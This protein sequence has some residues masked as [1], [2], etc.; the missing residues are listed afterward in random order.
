MAS[1]RKPRPRILASTAPR[2]A[3]GVTAAAIASVT[4]LS[5][6]ANAAPAKPSISEVKAQIDTLNQQA[7]VATENY[8]QAKERVDTQRAKTNQLLTQVAQKTQQLNESRRVLGQFASEQYRDGGVDQT[9]QLLLAPDPQQF[10][11]QTHMVNQLSATQ[12]EALKN[13]QVQQEQASIQ[14]S[15]A[16][17]SL[18]QLTSAQ[19][20]LA[21]Q[22]KTVQTKLAAAQKLL[23]SLNAEQRAKIAKMDKGSSSSAS[24]TYSG[25]ATG[26]AAAAINFALAQRGK[27]YVW[28]A[29]GPGSYDCSGLT[30][31][32]YRAAG[33][34][35][36]RTTSDQATKGI[37]VSKADLRPGDLVFFY[38]G[39]SHVGI[40]LGN[41]QIVHAPHTGAV[42][43]VAPLSWMPFATARRVA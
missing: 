28:G 39:L 25:P 22:K 8:N 19:Q 15:Q 27:P 2:A 34:T 21:G 29:T 31:A 41:G 18:A 33:V 9:V 30:Q 16:T 42:V 43:E 23:N 37:A 38:S 13:F 7:E 20:Q 35:I 6:S 5:E 3:V 40:Y 26:R 11:N 12:T 14:R 17:A 36:G 10:L 4:L 24:Y 32:A 1:H